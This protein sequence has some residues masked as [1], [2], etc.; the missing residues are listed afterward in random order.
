MSLDNVAVELVEPGVNY[1]PL[2]VRHCVPASFW[3]TLA[4]ILMS[5]YKVSSLFIWTVKKGYLLHE[6][7]QVNYANL[8]LAYNEICPQ[9]HRFS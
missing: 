6:Q 5:S 1:V 4:S 9:I 7:L 3:K 2:P 8:S